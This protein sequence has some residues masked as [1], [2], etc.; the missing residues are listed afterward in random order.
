MPGRAADAGGLCD[1][2]VAA[3]ERGA[4]PLPRVDNVKKSAL[5]SEKD[6]LDRCREIARVYRRIEDMLDA[7]SWGPSVT[8]SPAPWNF[9]SGMSRRW[10]GRASARAFILIDEFQDSNVAQIHLAKL[11]GGSRPTSSLSATLTRAFTAFAAPA[12]RPS[13]SSS[14]SFGT[15]RVKRVTMSDNRRSTPAHPAHSLPGNPQQPRGRQRPVAGR[16]M[17]ARRTVLRA[18]Q[19]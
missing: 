7:E 11:L 15:D 12:A 18:H 6:I 13:T 3:L 1:R 5:S 14:L 4:F 8:S 2:Y 10:R 9:C 16:G 17:A 19:R